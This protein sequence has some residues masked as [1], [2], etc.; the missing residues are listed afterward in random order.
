M[1][2]SESP[3][4]PDLVTTIIPV[5]NRAFYLG[6][7]VKS[8]L[9]QAYPYI[10]ILLVDDGST[11]N[12]TSFVKDLGKKHPDVIR[13]FRIPN[14]GPGGAREYGRL[15]ARGE[16]I[17]YL[18]SDDRLLPNKFACQVDALREHPECDIAYGKTRL[19][20]DNGVILAAPF[21]KSGEKIDRLFPHLLVDRWWNTHTPLYRRS[22]C[23]LIGPWTTMRM[24][25]DWHYDARAGAL[26]TQLVYC[27]EFV[28]EHRQHT[29]ER[30]TG[31]CLSHEALCDF[32]ELIPMLYD[33][34]VRAGV[35][36]GSR[37][38]QHFSRWA[39][40]IARQLGTSGE[41]MLAETCYQTAKQADRSNGRRW[42]Y[43]T[44]SLSRSIL[45][46]KLTG[47]LFVYLE[48]TIRRKAGKD[49]LAQSWMHQC[50]S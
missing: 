46:W 34:A 27:D 12:T 5:Y 30:L 24:A 49:T 1:P 19:I 35:M 20:D 50:R 29:Q 10:E 17:Q 40:S 44:I 45:G 9:E 36:R 25:E 42:D 28:S 11:D 18:D 39:F 8:V 21:K 2:S 22:L 4:V 32:G 43:R 48:R 13:C 14:S 23:H 15:Q 37:E 38:M 3:I 47:R 41:S 7:A 6:D 16:F 26:N 31:G 33:C